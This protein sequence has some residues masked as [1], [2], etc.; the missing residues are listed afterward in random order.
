MTKRKAVDFGIK[1]DQTNQNYENITPLQDE[2]EKALLQTALRK[3]KQGHDQ[4]ISEV[5]A[6]LDKEDCGDKSYKEPA[7]LIGYH[8]YRNIKK[9]FGVKK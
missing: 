7:L 4:A 5:F 8:T 3:Y 2:Y 9:K 1:N 6:E